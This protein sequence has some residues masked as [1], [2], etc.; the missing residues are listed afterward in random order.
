MFSEPRRSVL[1]RR[2]GL[3][4]TLQAALDG[5]WVIAAATGLI[6]FHIGALTPQYAMMLILLL[7]IVAIAY[8]QMAIYRSNRSPTLK[9]WSLFKG[10]SLSFLLLV[11]IGFASKQGHYFSRLLMIQLYLLGLAGHLVLH[12]IFYALQKTWFKH[13]SDTDRALVIG[14]GDLAN[15]LALKINSNPWMGQEL[16]GT[17]T[18]GDGSR[19]EKLEFE[20]GEL[21]V[22]G[23]VSRLVSIINEQDIDVA[24]I[25]APLVGSAV[26]E[27]VYFTLLDNHIAVHWVPDIFSLRLV[28]HS[29]NEIA[30]IPVLTLSETPLTGTHLLLK[31][32][33]DKILSAII[34]ALI[35]PV[36]L[37]IAIA[38]KLDSQGPVFFRQERTGWNGKNFLIWKFRSM[39]VQAAETDLVE[40]AYR[41]DPRVTRVGAFLRRTSLDELPQLF[42]VLGGDMSL[43]GPRPHAI[44]HDEEYSQRIADYFARHNIKPGITG[45]A[46]VRGFRGETRQLNQ[47][48]QRIECDIEYIN[49]WS[50]WLDFTILLRTTRAFTGKYAY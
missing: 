21:P 26:L 18:L 49:N 39:Y 9:A 34:L 2:N 7:G 30:G 20:P 23:S 50:L 47:M 40:Q 13:R 15:Y 5:A 43:V 16:V 29:V 36:L 10:W 24:Y 31:N 6:R 8:D 42:N 32:L 4:G 17:V 27:E 25:V 41:D 46:Q 45:L 33:E 28:N 3:S 11:F 19:E 35:S 12:L 1:K 44:Q 48:V 22:L 14:Q 38:I 37:V